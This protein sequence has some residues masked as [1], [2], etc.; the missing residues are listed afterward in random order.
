MIYTKHL[1]VT[2][3]MSDTAK[4]EVKSHVLKF[5]EIKPTVEILNYLLKYDPTEFEFIPFQTEELAITACMGDGLM[6]K[7]V[8]DKYKTDNVRTAALRQN[9]LALQ[10]IDKDKQTRDDHFNAVISTF[11]SVVYL[12]TQTEEIMRIAYQE[13]AKPKTN[14]SIRD[15]QLQLSK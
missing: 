11:D 6:L 5:L 1:E 12:S 14:K 15:E 8:E 4:K 3:I 10:F 2:K 9:G 13:L 7:F